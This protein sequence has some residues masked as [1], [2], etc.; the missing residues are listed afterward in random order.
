MIDVVDCGKLKPTPC[1]NEGYLTNIFIS[2][3]YN[4]PST[5]MKLLLLFSTTME[6]NDGI[7]NKAKFSIILTFFPIVIVFKLD[8]E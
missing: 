5:E 3:V 1:L 4:T 8:N 6:V 2:F 7:L